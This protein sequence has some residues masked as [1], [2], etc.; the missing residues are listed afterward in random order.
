MKLSEVFEALENDKKLS[1]K[2]KNQSNFQDVNMVLLKEMT[3]NEL[4]ECKFLYAPIIINGYRLEPEQ[5][6]LD[7]DDY[8]YIPSFSDDQDLFEEFSWESDSDL[9]QFHL[10]N[11]LVYLTPR[12]A[13]KHVR[14]LLNI[15]E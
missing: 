12:D 10:K 5:K 7:E 8:Y 15:K 9:C 13:E 6:P 11:N 1:V 2:F 4:Q 3:F 14:A